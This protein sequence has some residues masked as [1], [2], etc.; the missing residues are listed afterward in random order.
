MN[1]TQCDSNRIL[2]ASSVIL[3]LSLSKNMRGLHPVIH[4]NLN[5]F[6]N[7]NLVLI[8]LRIALDIREWDEFLCMNSTGI[9]IGF[10]TAFS[11]GLD[12][13]IRKK[14]AKL[15][16]PLSRHVFVCLDHY[17]HTLPWIAFTAWLVR[18]NKKISHLHILYA[19]ILSTWFAF[20][21]NG[22]LD[23]SET[24]VPHPWKRAWIGALWGMIATRQFVN[25]KYADKFYG[26]L[27]ILSILIP[28]SSTKFDSSI[29]RIY[30]LDFLVQNQ[31]ATKETQN[32]RRVKS[33]CNPQYTM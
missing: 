5:A 26:I 24:Y 27:Y 20:R 32:V 16:L 23:S 21:Q 11:Q 15:G 13:N 30:H 7:W 18:K 17:V 9:F 33:W 8:A 14:L 28:L 3:L 10:R 6:T 1:L 2:L 4:W 22:K 19:M 31:T 12:D 25:C 29:K